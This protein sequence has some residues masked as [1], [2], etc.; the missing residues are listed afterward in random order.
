MVIISLN[1]INITYFD[2]L[3]QCQNQNQIMQSRLKPMPLFYQVLYIKIWLELEQ[4]A[5]NQAKNVKDTES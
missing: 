2:Y 4:D 3:I 1:I 5:V